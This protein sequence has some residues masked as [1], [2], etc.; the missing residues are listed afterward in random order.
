MVRETQ[1]VAGSPLGGSIPSPNHEIDLGLG[2]TKTPI[3]SKVV[4]GLQSNLEYYL[5]MKASFTITE[6]LNNHTIVWL[7]SWGDQL[8]GMVSGECI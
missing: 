4:L 5:V 7:R 8:I 3:N 1:R 6:P 2:S